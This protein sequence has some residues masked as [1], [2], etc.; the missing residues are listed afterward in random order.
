LPKVTTLAFDE[1]QNLPIKSQ[2]LKPICHTTN[3]KTL[4]ENNPN[5]HCTAFK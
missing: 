2:M 1:I 4:Y 5:I 3:L